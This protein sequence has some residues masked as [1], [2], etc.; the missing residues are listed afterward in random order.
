MKSILL[1]LHGD[2]EPWALIAA[3][4]DL[5]RAVAGHVAC[6]E[7]PA[8]PRAGQVAADPP[9]HG[10]HPV[11]VAGD[12]ALRRRRQAAEQL[13]QAAGIDSVWRCFAAGVVET[14]LAE[15]R[16]ADVVVIGQPLVPR[17][18]HDRALANVA[19]L[20][21]HIRVPVLLVPPLS[22]GLAFAGDA[23]LAWN[24]SA[25]AAQALRGA[26]PLFARA[27]RVHVVEVADDIDPGGADLPTREAI[28]YLARAG[29]AAECHD[30][31]AKGRRTSAALRDAARELAVGY[32]VMGGHAHRRTQSTVL[33]TVTR[34]M[35]ETSALP[36]MLAS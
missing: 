25:E 28:A 29:I 30:W 15:S 21:Q 18:G 10:A 6:V 5:A 2:G 9:G 22:D 13:L 20:L 19:D 16:L 4:R 23:M 14:L 3:A 32:V 26:L 36:L 35:I 8:D 31:P 33:G 7:V 24:G 11:P 17:S 34:E 1:H 12:S 27:A